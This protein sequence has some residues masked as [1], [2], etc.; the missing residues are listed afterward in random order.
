MTKYYGQAHLYQVDTGLHLPALYLKLSTHNNII[1]QDQLLL[2]RKINQYNSVLKC[3][4]SCI[5]LARWV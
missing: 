2:F 1:N 4:S 5:T 3:C